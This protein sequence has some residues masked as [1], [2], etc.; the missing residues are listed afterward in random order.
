MKTDLEVKVHNV[1]D[2]IDNTIATL[3]L[4]ALGFQLDKLTDEQK[5]YLKS[6]QEGTT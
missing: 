6:W 3:K 2:E 5:R 4:D 1:P